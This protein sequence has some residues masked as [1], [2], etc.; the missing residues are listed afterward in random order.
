MMVSTVGKQCSLAEIPK[1]FFGFADV[2]DKI[3]LC[4]PHS[5]FIHLLPVC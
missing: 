5:Q 1:H 4:A 3:V 2:E